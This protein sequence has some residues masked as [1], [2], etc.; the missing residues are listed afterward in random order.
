MEKRW[1][2]KDQ[3]SW[4]DMQGC[5]RMGAKELKQREGMPGPPHPQVPSAHSEVVRAAGAPA[6]REQLG[7]VGFPWLPGL[8]G[9]SGT[10]HLG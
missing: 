9:G 6:P 1:L 3:G 7:P 10:S 4:A 5:G 8:S 2:Q